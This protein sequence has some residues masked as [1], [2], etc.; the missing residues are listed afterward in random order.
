MRPIDQMILIDIT[1]LEEILLIG[2]QRC[3]TVRSLPLHRAFR[4]F[5]VASEPKRIADERGL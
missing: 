4:G 2:H 1:H 3:H 5:Q